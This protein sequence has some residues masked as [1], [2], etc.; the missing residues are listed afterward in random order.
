M[1]NI[2]YLYVHIIAHS[3]GGLLA[4]MTFAQQPALWDRV[5][6]SGGRLLMLGTPN[7]GAHVIGRTLLGREKTVKMLAAVDLQ[8]N[9]KQLLENFLL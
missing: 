7:N 3:M 4:R 5:V 8:H 1:P 2:P 9:Q 6:A